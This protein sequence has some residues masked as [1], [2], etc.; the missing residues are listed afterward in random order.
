MLYLAGILVSEKGSRVS[1]PPKSETIHISLNGK[2]DSLQIPLSKIPELQEYLATV[3]DQEMELNRI[4][5]WVFP[6]EHGLYVVLEYNCGIKLCDS[7][8]I[9]KKGEE[10]FTLSLEQ[11]M[12]F[13]TMFFA[14]D[15][16]KAALLFSYPLQYKDTYFTK[17]KIIAI[18]TDTLQKLKGT[19]DQ[20]VSELT[21]PFL[22]YK[23]RNDDSVE[24]SI[25]KVDEYSDE[26]IAE[27]YQT[28]RAETEKRV[29]Q[30]E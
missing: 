14:P 8:L 10:Y 7:I 17:D 20:I 13:K 11:G 15:Q 3:E 26:K 18:N 2:E 23:W 29:V 24:I 21:V 19:N 22:E 25:P 6:A 1:T 27:W 5:S 16:T 30:Y 4:N 28:E 12:V 9:Q